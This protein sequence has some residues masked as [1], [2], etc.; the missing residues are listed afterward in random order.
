MERMP[1]KLS[2][3]EIKELT[4]KEIEALKALGYLD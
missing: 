1:P 3:V 2:P 4:Q